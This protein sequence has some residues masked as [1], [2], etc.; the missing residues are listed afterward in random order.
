MKLR[1]KY[2]LIGAGVGIVVSCSIVAALAFWSYR[3]AERENTAPHLTPGAVASEIRR[4]EVVDSTGALVW[5]IVNASAT[6][7]EPIDY[8]TVPSGFSQLFPRIGR[9]RQLETHEHLRVS[10]TTDT[11][12]ARLNAWQRPRNCFRFGITTGGQ[13][14][15]PDREMFVLSHKPQ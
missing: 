11:G 8:G 14:P 7:T 3:A 1:R 12:W 15:L 13:P 5:S 6:S 4:L 10:Y 2:T 9:P